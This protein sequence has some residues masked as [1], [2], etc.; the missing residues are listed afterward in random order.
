MAA[1]GHQLLWTRR[2]I[3]LLGAS[4]ESSARVFGTFFLGLSVGSAIAALVVGRIRNPLRFAGWVQLSIPVLI[5]PVIYLSGLTDWI[6]PTL[7]AQSVH[8]SNGYAIKSFL[9]LSIVLPPSAMMGLS[10]PLIVA[11]VLRLNRGRLGRSGIHLYAINTLG[12]ASGVLFTVMIALPELGNFASMILAGFV[13]GMV[14]VA[15][16]LYS[17][18]CD[19][20]QPLRG[21]LAS[22]VERG[23]GKPFVGAIGL[24]FFS[25]MAVLALEVTALQMFQLVATIS[26]FSPAAVLFCAIASLGL[27]AAIFS[28]FESTLMSAIRGRAIVLILAA[29]G[30]L[31][32]LAPQIFMG[33]ARRSNWFASNEGVSEFVFELGALALLSVGPAWL[34]AGLIFPFAVASAGEHCS[35]IQSGRRLG[36]LLA[37]NGIGGLLGAEL[38]YRVLLPTCGVYGAMAVIAAGLAMTAIVVSLFSSG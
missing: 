27:S 29:S 22:S 16:L 25:G 15:L 36:V 10:F 26:L 30:I 34:V 12:G 18:S 38:A 4:G 17:R 35:S 11:G 37:V 21:E 2:L 5:I 28:R 6:W 1:L 32:V 33:I 8:G 13:D 24:A 19:F 3:D 9:T 23:T 14:G 31:V 7:G 20:S